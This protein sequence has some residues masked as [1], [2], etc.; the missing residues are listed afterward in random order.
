MPTCTPMRAQLLQGSERY[1]VTLPREAKFS[2]AEM[3]TWMRSGQLGCG[4][5]TPSHRLTGVEGGALPL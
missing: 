5:R 1:N 2:L 4:G 3:R